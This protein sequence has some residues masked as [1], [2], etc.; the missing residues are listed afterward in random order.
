MALCGSA[1]GLVHP[2]EVLTQGSGT[3]PHQ[4]IS[5][6]IQVLTSARIDAVEGISYRVGQDAVMAVCL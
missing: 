5:I 3:E 1:Q 2:P 6:P 4:P